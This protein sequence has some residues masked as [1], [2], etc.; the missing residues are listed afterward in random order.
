MLLKEQPMRYLQN[1]QVAT[2]TDVFKSDSSSIARIKNEQGREYIKAV[3]TKMFIE[4]FRFF[5]ENVSID[6]YQINNLTDLVLDSYGYFNVADFALFF[7]KAKKADFGGIYGSIQPFTIMEW[8]V[9]YKAER[10]NTAVSESIEE[11]IQREKQ[12][13][14]EIR[15]GQIKT[16]SELMDSGNFEN[17][18]NILGYT[19]EDMIKSEEVMKVKL[20]W[21]HKMYEKYNGPVCEKYGLPKGGIDVNYNR[22]YTMDKETYDKLE[23]AEKNGILTR[24]IL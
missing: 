23:T 11:S 10:M 8:L 14:E 20:N 12:V 6:A 15:T 4:F 3:L 18:A 1:M 5:G 16:F 13:K 7:K 21:N 19:K 17:I 2:F 22:T 9:K 24:I